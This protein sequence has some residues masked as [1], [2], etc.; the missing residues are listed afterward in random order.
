MSLDVYLTMDGAQSPSG[1]GIFM[2]EAGSTREISR[3]EW[4][5]AF[6]GREPLVATATDD[7]GGEVY[8][9]NITHNLSTMAEHAGIYDACWRPY[10][11][12]DPEKAALVHAQE[13]ARNFHG[14]DG[15]FELERSIAPI[16]AALLIEPLR[17]GLALLESDPERF[18]RHNPENGWGSYEG[19]VSFVRGYLRACERYPQA[20]VSVSR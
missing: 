19:L 17:A 8:E 10:R 16:H 2:R 6:P 9:A 12:A 1:S 20:T 13:E 5:R 18:R 11:I 4:D 15:A 7:G 14:P 3:D